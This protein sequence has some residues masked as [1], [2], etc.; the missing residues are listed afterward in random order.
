MTVLGRMSKRCQSGRE[1][2]FHL[3]TS[4]DYNTDGDHPSCKVSAPPVLAT[5]A[6]SSTRGRHNATY[7]TSTYDSPPAPSASNATVSASS[8]SG[9]K[10]KGKVYSVQDQFAGKTF[11][12]NF[13]F[14][15]FADPT[16]GN[17]NYISE[18]QAINN[19]AYVQSDGVAVMKV[20]NTTTIQSGG[21]RDSVRI[22]SKKSYS[23]GLF[24]LDLQSMPTGCGTWPAFWLV[25]P[26]WPSNGEIDIV[27]GVNNNVNGQYTLH[28][29]PGCTL[30]TSF[31]KST[32]RRRRSSFSDRSHSR[33]AV[34]NANSAMAF[35][36]V[37]LNSNCDA[38]LDSNTGC[39]VQDP[40]KQSYGVPL[41]A[42]GGGVFAT[43]LDA[44][45]IAIWFFPRASVPADIASQKPQPSGWGS[46]KAF[47]S[48]NSCP[49]TKYFK[50][51]QIVINT[52]LCG[53]W[54]GSVYSSSGC[55]GTC[56]DR[57]ADPS[58]FDGTLVNK[59]PARVVILTNAKCAYCSPN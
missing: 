23:T 18:S 15:T 14:D 56:A 41:N 45:G 25:G 42:N 24:V 3:T 51:Q 59:N 11:F 48:S 40:S 26:N 16:H 33:R 1:V 37:V 28:T 17:V 58:N 4:L 52:T 12:N 29:D 5:T 34:A 57:V 50:S 49:S 47:W 39:A 38:L 46:P 31:D 9:G 36:G 2:Q 35:T 20:D 44:N 55:P 8:T 21:N 7:P 30:D 32:S 19:L 27:E 6:S 53:D 22:T 10:G 13:N 54:A 43:L